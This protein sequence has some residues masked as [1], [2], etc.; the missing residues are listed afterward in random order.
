M[1]RILIIAA[2]I[3]TLSLAASSAP[4]S[5]AIRSFVG[6]FSVSGAS[7]PISTWGGT[8]RFTFDTAANPVD[9]FTPDQFAL[10]IGADV[11]DPSDT[12]VDTATSPLSIGARDF[13][14]GRFGS[15]P[16]DTNNSTLGPRDFRYRA[17]LDSA[18]ELISARGQYRT[19]TNQ[20]GSFDTTS[21]DGSSATFAITAIPEPATWALM[22]AGFA[23]TG[24][25]L[26]R[27][28]RA[29]VAA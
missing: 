12:R 22:I 2:A 29:V 28:P 17:I 27:R 10:T 11:F 5:A 6:S 15:A 19:A 3:G 13:I 21:G 4:A 14:I 16:G 23:A 9:D 26:R 1:S 24:A 7:G 20:L 18:G 8:F 25:A